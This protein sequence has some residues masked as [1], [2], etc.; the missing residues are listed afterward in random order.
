MELFLLISTVKAF[1]KVL[2]EKGGQD[3]EKKFL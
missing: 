1:R 2:A 3:P